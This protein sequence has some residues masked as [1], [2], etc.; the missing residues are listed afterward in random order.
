MNTTFQNLEIVNLK[1]TA[2]CLPQQ[3]HHHNLD[4]DNFTTIFE[5]KGTR[6]LY[7]IF[8]ASKLQCSVDEFC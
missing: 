6:K 4:T 1:R 5:R 2:K 7:T 8:D 3:N